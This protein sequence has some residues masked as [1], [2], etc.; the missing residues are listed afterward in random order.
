MTTSTV[1]AVREDPREADRAVSG[2][3]ARDDEAL[4]HP[5]HS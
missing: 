5:D 3:T 1:G 4:P 2:G